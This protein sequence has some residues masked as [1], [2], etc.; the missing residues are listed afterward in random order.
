MGYYRGVP[1][2]KRA[3]TDQVASEM[4][5][6]NS[7]VVKIRATVLARRGSGSHYPKQEAVR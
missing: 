7:R 5:R 3:R 4:R 2:Q 6:R 1:H